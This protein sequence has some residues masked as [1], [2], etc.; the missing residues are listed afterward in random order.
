ML[1]KFINNFFLMPRFFFNV[2]RNKIRISLFDY[3]IEISQFSIQ[4]ISIQKKILIELIYQK[5]YFLLEDC[6][7]NKKIENLKSLL[8]NLQSFKKKKIIFIYI[9]SY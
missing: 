3:K 8:K 2:L 1:K 4:K 9:Y 6:I 7:H 5:N